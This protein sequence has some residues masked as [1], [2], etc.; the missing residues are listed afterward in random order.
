M[1]KVSDDDMALMGRLLGR[2]EAGEK[3]AA[4]IAALL[5]ALNESESKLD[6]A[7]ERFSDVLSQHGEVVVTIKALE[8]RL[9]AYKWTPEE[10]EECV[11]AANTAE[12]KTADLLERAVNAENRLDACLNFID[13]ISIDQDVNPVF[14]DV[15][16]KLVAG[17]FVVESQKHLSKCSSCGRMVDG[18]G[19][20]GFGPEYACECGSLWT[21]V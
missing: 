17:E 14:R 16:R 5:D 4:R 20:S 10:M 2:G 7:E 1:A 13:R 18:F 15:A 6:A 12:E 21:G 3:G 9:A 8:S 19:D 11:N